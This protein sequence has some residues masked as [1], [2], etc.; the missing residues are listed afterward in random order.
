MSGS[1]AEEEEFEETMDRIE[2]LEKG[3][4]DIQKQ[5]DEIMAEAE[6]RGVCLIPKKGEDF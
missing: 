1:I 5:L 4:F 6:K 3:I 2:K